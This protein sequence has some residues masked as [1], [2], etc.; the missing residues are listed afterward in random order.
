MLDSVT[1]WLVQLGLG[2]YAEA[3]EKNA[4]ELTHL[5]NLDHEFLRAI[6]VRATGYRMTILEAAAKPNVVSSQ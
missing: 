1:R 2:Q 6:G 5:P 4:V 3:F